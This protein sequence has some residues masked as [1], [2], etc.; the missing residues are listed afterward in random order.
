[1][2]GVFSPFFRFQSRGSDP[3]PNRSPELIPVT[4]DLLWID[5]YAHCSENLSLTMDARI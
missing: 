3:R 1:M 5:S 4:M 2:Q